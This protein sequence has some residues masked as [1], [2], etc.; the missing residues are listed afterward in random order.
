MLQVSD[1]LRRWD[2]AV[3]VPM[4]QEAKLETIR[5]RD[6]FTFGPGTIAAFVNGADRFDY[7]PDTNIVQWTPLAVQ[8]TDRHGNL[9][10]VYRLE[11][12]MDCRTEKV[13]LA[14]AEIHGI[15]MLI[16]ST[17]SV[18]WSN[19]LTGQIYL[20]I[21][22]DQGSANNIFLNSWQIFRI[23]ATSSR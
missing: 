12:S 11:A 17:D 13:T 10:N 9:G 19:P 2:E 8:Y 1:M 18:N 6:D 21:Q 22:V 5:K 16:R 14:K 4:V 3:I 15:M 7:L 23:S 20:Q